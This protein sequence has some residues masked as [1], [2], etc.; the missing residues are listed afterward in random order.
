MLKNIFTIL[1]KDYRIELSQ[2]HLFFSVVLYLL[3]SIYIIYIAFQPLGI[4]NVETWVSI[5]WVIILFAAITV[6]SKS[7]FQESYKRNYYY[8]YLFTPDELIFSKLIYNFIFL[9]FVS[10]FSF[11]FF[12]FFIGNIIRS[13]IFFVT[14]LLL[15]SLSIS[16]CLT[17]VSAIGYQVK[18]NSIII[19]VL[20]FP[21]IIPILL[22]LIKISKLSSS[23]FSFNL[24]QD[25]IY[26]LILL[27][28]IMISITKI[29]F[30]FLWRN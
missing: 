16:N 10:I 9:F 24:I 4:S 20:S 17:L 1:Y 15:G 23:E 11:I 19:S 6:V 21:V 30:N 26:L 25:D 13:P 28:I 22:I 5:F 27:N 12:S 3:S 7:F 8:Y 18:N 2:S 14:L 29:L